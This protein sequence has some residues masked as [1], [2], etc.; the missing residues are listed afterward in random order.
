MNKFLIYF[1]NKDANGQSFTDSIDLLFSDIES[2]YKSAVH[3]LGIEYPIIGDTKSTLMMMTRSQ[4]LASITNIVNHSIAVGMGFLHYED[5][6][7]HP[8]ELE[9]EIYFSSENLGKVNIDYFR[10]RMVKLSLTITKVGDVLLVSSPDL[11]PDPEYQS[12]SRK[13]PT[14]TKAL[15]SGG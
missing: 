15:I 3:D 5:K 13:Y 10:G 2:A 4:L 12:W 7:Y 9:S 6:C 8:S 1:R 11:T 14:Y